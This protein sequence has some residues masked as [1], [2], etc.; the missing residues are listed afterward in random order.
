[1]MVG[2][3]DRQERILPIFLLHHRLSLLFYYIYISI[4]LM[5]T[6]YFFNYEA[7][8]IPLEKYEGKR[9]VFFHFVNGL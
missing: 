5:S 2:L 9:K 4:I 8:L 6:S 7:T 3:E 1:M